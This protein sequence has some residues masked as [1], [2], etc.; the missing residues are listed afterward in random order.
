[1]NNKVIILCFA[2]VAA[3]VVTAAALLA[4][5]N[6]NLKDGE[7]TISVQGTAATEIQADTARFGF[8]VKRSG[9]SGLGK[10]YNDLQHDCAQALDMMYTLGFTPGDIDSSAVEC[11][12][13]YARSS[14]GYITNQIEGY[15]L[16]QRFTVTTRNID[17]AEYGRLQPQQLMS[18]GV[19][20]EVFPLS[21]SCSDS[22]KLYSQLLAAASAN[23]LEKA[24]KI[25][26]AGGFKIGTLCSSPAQNIEVTGDRTKTITVNAYASYS[27]NK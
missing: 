27:V 16:V 22:E 5:M 26:A 11:S 12:P 1:M 10:L 4:N 20:V 24:E 7:N 9:H 21:Y 13:I 18:Q 2:I 25:A 8:A 17:L 14:N 23:A 19:E 6:I 3:A 15:S